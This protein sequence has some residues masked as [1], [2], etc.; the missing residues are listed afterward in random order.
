[1]WTSPANIHLD[2]Q[3]TKHVFIY[4]YFTEDKTE[5]VFY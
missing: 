3:M 1:M 2:G 5:D 4:K